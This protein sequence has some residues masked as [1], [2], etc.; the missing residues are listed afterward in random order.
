MPLD[1]GEFRISETTEER[2]NELRPRKGR[3]K[4][5]PQW[6]GVLDDLAAG[7]VIE[8]EAPDPRRA[9]TLRRSLGRMAAGRDM[10]LELSGEGTTVL[11]RKS[12]QALVPKPVREALGKVTENGRRGGRRGKA[13]AEPAEPGLA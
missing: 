11:V 4:L 3:S 13:A 8:L 6:E 5:H 9:N 7:K 10:K 12:E 2:F 1:P